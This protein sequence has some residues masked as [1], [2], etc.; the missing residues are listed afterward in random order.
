MT[1]IINNGPRV[2]LLLQNRADARATSST[3]RLLLIIY[4]VGASAR[5][6]SS[7]PSAV[8]LCP[9]AHHHRSVSVAGAPPAGLQRCRNTRTPPG[10]GVGLSAEG[11]ATE[12]EGI[13][14]S[15]TACGTE[16]ELSL[17]SPW[18][19][20]RCVMRWRRLAVELWAVRGRIVSRFVFAITQRPSSQCHYTLALSAHRARSLLGPGS[21]YL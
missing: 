14:A 7:R 13:A 19:L 11:R 15:R 8:S 12:K 10:I 18:V 3:F 20:A 1:K 4:L 21:T 2:F 9:S 5:S 6:L 17:Y 16:A